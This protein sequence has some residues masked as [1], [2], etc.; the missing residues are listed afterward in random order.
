MPLSLVLLISA[1]IGVAAG[2]KSAIVCSSGQ[3]AVP[4]QTLK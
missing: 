3:G 2:L 4:L 1:Q